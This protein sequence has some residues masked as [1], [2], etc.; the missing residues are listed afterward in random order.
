MPSISFEIFPLDMKSST[1]TVLLPS[2]KIHSTQPQRISSEEQHEK[3]SNISNQGALD[4]GRAHLVIAAVFRDFE[5]GVYVIITCAI[6]EFYIATAKIH[7]ILIFLCAS[8]Q[9]PYQERY[10]ITNESNHSP[11]KN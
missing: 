11:T 3:Q 1:Q 6:L 8:L 2:Y 10:S 9:L 5:G 4:R 7:D